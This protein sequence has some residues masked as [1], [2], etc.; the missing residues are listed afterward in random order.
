VREAVAD[1]P[2]QERRLIELRFGLNG[3]PQSIEAI[4][5][6]LGMTRERVRKVEREAFAKLARSL[7]GASSD[8]D[9][10][11]LAVAA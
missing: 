11:E 6:E 7:S 10:D 4:G 2:E 5:R 9:S 1:L 8:E 3:E